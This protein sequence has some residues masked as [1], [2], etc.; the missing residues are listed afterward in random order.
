MNS[1]VR[2]GLIIVACLALFGGG[3]LL[4]ERN[5]GRLPE[6]SSMLEGAGPAGTNAGRLGRIARQLEI[7]DS[8]V[9][10]LLLAPEKLPSSLVIDTDRLDPEWPVL[11]IVADE[12][13]L[14]D[15]ENGILANPHERGREWER[16]A[17]ASYFERGELIFATR[18]GLRRHGD[19]SR[20]NPIRP[21]MRLYFRDEYGSEHS[22]Q[23]VLE[24]LETSPSRIVVRRERSFYANAFA[25]EIA[26]Q[27]GAPTPAF[28][29]AQVYLNGELLGDYLLTEHVHL[30]GWGLSRYGHKRLS[31]FSP[32]GAPSTDE[33][34]EAGY[35][36]L[37]GWLRN[38]AIPLSMEKVEMRI[39][40]G[41]MLRNIITFIYCGTNDWSQGAIVRDESRDDG[42]WFWLHWDLDHSFRTNEVIL[43]SL[44]AIKLIVDPV[45]LADRYDPRG[46]LFR[47]LLKEDPV[48]RD[49]FVRLATDLLN[50]RLQHDFFNE[51]LNRY[52]FALNGRHK[53]EYRQ[54]FKRRSDHVRAE[55]QQYLGVGRV[56]HVVVEAPDGFELEIDGYP[57]ASGYSG[58]Y[59]EGMEITLEPLGDPASGHFHWLV[60]GKR[61]DEHRLVLA[62][63]ETTKIEA[64]LSP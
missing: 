61:Y 14:T 27:I 60:N 17:F 42:R 15:P 9:N 56:H 46:I 31:M 55:M 3:G 52:D 39:D 25:F 26:R 53:R 22:G 48:F 64:M 34:S 6:R 36:E 59:F 29:L 44:P 19:A 11:S 49:V 23:A 16:L 54:F 58:A 5:V 32:R 28:K 33:D 40:L 4:L 50:H 45:R 62:I 12:A 21:S 7:D 1:K 13:D 35:R 10:S 24:E 30:D 41:N 38:P 43:E 18:A 8:T 51:L 20:D 63:E 57:E 37:V 2:D 47:R